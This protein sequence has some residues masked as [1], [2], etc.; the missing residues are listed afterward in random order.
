MSYH[1]LV[2]HMS[3]NTK[4]VFV[5]FKLTL[6]VIKHTTNL[7][8]NHQACHAQEYVTPDL[9]NKSVVRNK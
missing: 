5:L 4:V 2:F 8:T 3:H 6:N 7:H 1:L 9:I